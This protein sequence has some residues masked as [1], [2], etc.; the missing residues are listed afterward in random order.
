M[1]I[2]VFCFL[3]EVKMET[4]RCDLCPNGCLLKEG[5][6][7]I[8]GARTARDGQCV[9]YQ[10]GT[11]AAVH[12]DP[13]EKKPLYPF[14]PGTTALSLGGL[15]CNLKCRGCQN[16]SLSR[17]RA[18][19]V[20]LQVYDAS[21][22]VRAACLQNCRSIAYTY[23]E[24]LI[25]WEFMDEIAVL[26]REN[27]IKNI[28]V[29]AGYV[30]DKSRE[31]V[32]AHIDAANV[33]LKGFSEDFYQTWAHGKLKPILETL[34]YLH[35]KK[36]FWLEVT[37]LL[38]PGMNDDDAMLRAEF[39]WIVSHLGTE[40]PLHLSAFHPACEAMD[41]PA[42][43]VE[44]LTHAGKLAHELGIS[45]VYLG[46]V[47]VSNDTVCQHC[48]TT[49]IR[50]WGYHVELCGLREGCCHRCGERLSGWFE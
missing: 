49:L 34:E 3:G 12:I 17:T 1:L 25:W 10:H 43:S 14:Y 13:V 11:L 20:K 26:A 45:H 30:S 31:K 35:D 32:F 40:V 7:G 42:T 8:C 22:V 23:N 28:L 48:G 36:D 15:G 16:D 21:S 39:E 5:Q 47:P 44:S 6:M 33:D 2:A 9:E 27:H 38:I 41:M 24:P 37:T 29:T 18:D 4:I 46:N 19:K 50:R